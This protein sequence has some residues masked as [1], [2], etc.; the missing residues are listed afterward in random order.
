MP[1]IRVVNWQAAKE[2]VRLAD[3]V[4]VHGRVVGA[5][6]LLIESHGPPAR[7]GEICLI[8]RGRHE[9]PLQVEV[10]GFRNGRTLLTPL[11]E[12]TG[13]APGSEVIPT[14]QTASVGVSDALLGRVLDGLGNPMDGKPAPP[15]LARYPLLADAPSALKRPPLRTPLPLGVRAIDALLTC[16]SG[17]RMGIFAGSGVGKST[18]MGMIARNTTAEVNV[19][20]LIGERGREVREFIEDSLGEE[21]LQRSVL[22]VATSDQPAIVRQK[23]AF[24]ATAIAEYFRDQGRQVVLMMDSLTRL[25]MAQREIGLS[26][27]EPPAARG[28]TP[29]V[30]ALMPRLLERAGNNAKGSIT[31]IYTVLVDGDDLNDPIA[32]T[33]RA[34]LDGHIVLSR[35]LTQQGHYPP[36]DVLASL[37]RVMPNIVSPEHQQAANRL[38]QLLAAYREAEDLIAIGAYQQGANPL[39]DIA[40]ARMDAIRQFLCQRREEQPGFEEILQGLFELTR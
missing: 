21:G 28:Y 32:D 13:V 17:Q 22:V 16:A 19:I 31:G 14:R 2:A 24:T 5:V 29:S 20:A 3:P 26:A 7:L 35:T 33:A 40:I 1:T 18:L 34:I 23:A 27:G 11:G 36:I 6:G 30:F 12:L 10:V 39:V 38:R 37:S 25:A 8:V 9:T 4:R 15:A